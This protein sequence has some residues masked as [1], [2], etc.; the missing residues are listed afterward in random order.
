MSSLNSHKTSADYYIVVVV[1]HKYKRWH[2]T[3]RHIEKVDW[4]IKSS[5]ARKKSE[6]RG[7]FPP[8]LRISFTSPGSVW[9][10]PVSI[11]VWSHLNGGMSAQSEVEWLTDLVG[12]SQRAA[13]QG[14]WTASRKHTGDLIEIQPVAFNVLLYSGQNC[15]LWNRCTDFIISTVLHCQTRT[16]ML[17]HRF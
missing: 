11:L 2:C 1:Y 14:W 9:K 15:S 3:D 4:S 16:L 17:Y 7:W 8:N 12:F 6:D 5:K 10:W 13:T